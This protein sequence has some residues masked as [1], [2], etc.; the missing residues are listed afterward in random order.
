[1]KSLRNIE[2]VRMLVLACAGVLFVG[3]LVLHISDVAVD[4]NDVIRLVLTSL[5]SVLI[6]FRS[7]PEAKGEAAG[8]VV[9]LAAGGVGAA[10]AVGG[11]VFS[12]SQIDSSVEKPLIPQS[13]NLCES[14]SET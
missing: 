2:P 6:L 11:L 8:V 10:M 13:E 1:M 4:Q 14:A 9:L 12:V 5:F 7:K 3:W